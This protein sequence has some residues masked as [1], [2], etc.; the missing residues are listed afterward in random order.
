MFGVIGLRARHCHR[1]LRWP[2][3]TSDRRAREVGLKH[4]QEARNCR[5]ARKRRRCVLIPLPRL[6]AMLLDLFRFP[7]VYMRKSVART[8]FRSK[9]FVELGV[10]GLR[11]TVLCTLDEE[12]H[13]PRRECGDPMPV[14]RVR[15]EQQPA[16][17]VC[18]EDEECRRMGGIYAEAGE[19]FSNMHAGERATLQVGSWGEIR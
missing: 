7:I 6:H 13:A 5:E 12:R 18:N 19:E 16:H 2:R 11:I 17:R 3:V 10:N 1:S 14:Q 8:A 9:K 4:C 15:L